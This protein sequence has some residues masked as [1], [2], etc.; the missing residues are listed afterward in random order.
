RSTKGG[1]ARLA[2]GEPVGTVDFTNPTARE[3]WKD[4]LK[5]LVADGAWVFKPDYGDRVPDDALFH[6]GRTGVEMHNLFLHHYVE[7]AWQAVHETRGEAIVW[8]RPGYI[9]TQR[10]PG[11]W[12]GA[13]QA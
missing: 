7:A 1:I 6:D 8:R 5:Q 3:W 4:K 11:T 13:T 2:Y 12:A 9:G 10:Y